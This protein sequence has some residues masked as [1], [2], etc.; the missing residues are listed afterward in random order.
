MQ[1]LHVVS[2]MVLSVPLFAGCGLFVD[3]GNPSAANDPAAQGAFVTVRVVNCFGE[4][5]ESARAPFPSKFTTVSATA[6]GLV[7]GHRVS[8]PFRL[9]KLT[10]PGLS[11]LR[12]DKPNEGVWLLYFRVA[13][14]GPYYI[15]GF[16]QTVTS[17]LVPVRRGA[18]EI[19]TQPVRTPA[20]PDEIDAALRELSSGQPY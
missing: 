19:G 11:V 17:A 20:R 15:G 12:W 1:I 9:E 18:A 5:R 13:D 3:L 8:A 14:A 7:N 16:P 2:L 6:E 4:I 10:T